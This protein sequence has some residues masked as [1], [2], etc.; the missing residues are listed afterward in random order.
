MA[1]AAIKLPNSSTSQFVGSEVVTGPPASAN[2]KYQLRAQ[3]LGV[4][5][6]TIRAKLWLNGQPEPALWTLNQTDSTAT[7]Q[8][9]GS[10]ALSSF[11]SGSSVPLV[12][13][14]DDL[15]VQSTN[16]YPVVSFARNCVLLDCT[17]DAAATIDPDGSVVNYEWSFGD[18][19][20]ATG[21]TPA[22]VYTAAG[23]Y[24]VTM[25]A[26]DDLG[27][28]AGGSQTF[29]V[30]VGGGGNLNPIAAF[31]TSCVVL[32]CT[33]D[34]SASN[35]PDGS[36]VSHDWTFSDGATASGATASHS[37]ATVGTWP[38]SLVVTDD[39]N[40]TDSVTHDAVTTLPPPIIADDFSR[41]VSGGWGS[42]SPGGA[43]SL[44]GISS[45]FAVNG[46]VATH[47]LTAVNTAG[48]ARLLSTP[49]ADADVQVRV[50]TD[51]VPVGS[52]YWLNVVGR[53]VSSA[54]EYRTRVRFSSTGLFVGAYRVVNG[55]S[56]SV[57]GAEVPT[58]LVATPGQFYRI[59]MNVS[60]TNPTT[61]KI[62]VWLDGAT[63][64]T[65][66]LVTQTDFSASI[67]APGTVGLTTW[68]QGTTLLPLVFSFDDLVVRPAN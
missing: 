49:L 44:S 64:P 23:I 30:N 5:P 55:G 38:V 24:T 35:D 54:N 62:K 66:W 9:P 17:F 48:T 45:N 51:Q 29:S 43:W 33:F 10:I 20:I 59:R 21:N 41:T 13:S 46:S 3:V 18:G 36:I 34:A 26:T 1:L 52:G 19:S 4:N 40:A 63:E 42:A 2:Q 12:F 8:A 58:G 22:H 68:M 60:G 61:I 11:V 57:I 31:T 28:R 65:N 37:F 67:Q 53:S 47:K 56:S 16:R 25:T 14:F 32:D 27:A 50:A 39:L 7:I 15:V 6:T